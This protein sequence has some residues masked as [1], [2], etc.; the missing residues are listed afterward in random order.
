MG[1][2]FETCAVT[3]L[4]IHEG[5]RIKLIFLFGDHNPW[6]LPISGEYNDYGCIENIE[7][8]WVTELI[9]SRLDKDFVYEI[10][11]NVKEAPKTIEEFAFAVERGNVILDDSLT[12]YLHRDR[13]INA[14]FMMVL[15]SVY[16]KARDLYKEH[17]DSYM[18][19][20]YEQ[21]VEKT[22]LKIQIDFESADRLGFSRNDQIRGIFDRFCGIRWRSQE[23]QEKI[24]EEKSTDGC[25][26]DCLEFQ[27]FIS[28][29]YDTR[30][31][32]IVP[33]GKGSQTEAL[34]MHKGINEFALELIKKEETRYDE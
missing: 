11:S 32:F 21:H 26:D 4:P 13:K 19:D 2:W 23:L 12:K 7:K 15:E 10:D 27:A 33:S 24:C 20:D 14:S 1:C 16:E 31:S 28:F 6:L 22:K 18:D 3:N 30:R 34:E 25:V 9:E 5:D 29:M 17:F 8:D